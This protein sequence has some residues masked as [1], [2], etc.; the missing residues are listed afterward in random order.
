[1]WNLKSA[2]VILITVVT[3]GGVPRTLDDWVGK[4]SITLGTS[5]LQRAALLGTARILRKVFDT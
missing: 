3:L 4:L 5:L 2:Q 1:M